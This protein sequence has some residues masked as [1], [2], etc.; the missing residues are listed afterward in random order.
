MLALWRRFECEECK[1]FEKIW[2]KIQSLVRDEHLFMVEF[3][4]TVILELK[5]SDIGNFQKIKRWKT[6][7]CKNKQNRKFKDVTEQ[8]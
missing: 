1:D 4:W 8:K 2:K 6:K 5:K 7:V 3:F